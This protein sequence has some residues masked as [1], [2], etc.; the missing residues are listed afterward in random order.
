MGAFFSSMDDKLRQTKQQINR[1]IRELERQRMKYERDEKGIIQKLK[2]EAKNGRMQNMRLLAKDLVRSR[3]IAQ[4][5][6]SMKSQMTAILIQLQS[7]QSANMLSTNIKNVNYLIS[8]VSQKANIADFQKIIQSLGRESEI[9]NLKLDVM[10]ESLDNTLQDVESI[11][12]ED[13]V[14]TQILEELGIDTSAVLDSVANPP[15]KSASRQMA[16]EPQK[17]GGQLS[18]KNSPRNVTEE[19]EDAASLGS[20]VDNLKNKE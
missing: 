1:T 7:A 20:R 5:Y 2:S 9:V 19:S 3:K 15:T 11:E 4:H 8:K 17:V 10:S 12:E 18:A 14:I 16:V 6:C 13:K